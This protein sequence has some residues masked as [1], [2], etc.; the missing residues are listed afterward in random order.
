M[1]RVLPRRSATAS[2]AESTFFSAC[3]NLPLTHGETNLLRWYL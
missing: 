1:S 3:G 2:T